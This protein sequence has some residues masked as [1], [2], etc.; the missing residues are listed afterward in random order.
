V[1]EKGRVKLEE[2]DRVCGECDAV[3]FKTGYVYGDMYYC[4]EHEPEH[5]QRDFRRL[6]IIQEE[7]NSPFQEWDCYWTRFD[8]SDDY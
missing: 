7:E 3:G 1:T 8:T 6:A 2:L 4:E 5:F